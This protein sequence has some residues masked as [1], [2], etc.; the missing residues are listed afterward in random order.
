MKN[1][2]SLIFVAFAFCSCSSTE[3]VFLSVQKHAP[4]TV[5]SY[6]KSVG[7]VNRTLP[8]DQTKVVDVVDK[9]FSLE[10]A[11]L[12]RDGAQASITGLTDELQKNN[13]FTEVKTLK[14]D[15]RTNTPGLLP[16]PLPWDI[17][18]KICKENNTDALFSLEFFDTDTKMSYSATPTTITTG[19]GNV[20]GIEHHAN[21]LTNI[22][23]GWR[24]YDP[25]SK[26]ILDEYPLARSISFSA[27]GI[28]PAIAASGLIG[29]KDAVKQVGAEAGQTY[30]YRILPYWIRVSR[31]YYVRGTDNFRIARRKAQTGNWTDAASYW[32]KE[33]NNP[34]GKIAG[35]AC[36]NMAIVNEIN[37]DIDEAIQWAQKA[38][39]NYNNKLGL[40]YVRILQNRKANDEILKDQ[41]EQQQ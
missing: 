7:V 2:L 21:M 9:V 34:D 38:Y 37:G 19:L 14:T 27:K 32:A 25:L 15:L 30:A 28:N 18:E 41:Q 29:R 4:V 23:T 20:P 33:T 8:S 10:G 36:Y 5:P 3:L 17:V 35:R 40:R 39:E 31:D 24:I 16:T 13:R 6:I 1:R 11:N 12:D 22:K 26:N